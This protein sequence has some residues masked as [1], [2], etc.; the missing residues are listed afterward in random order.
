MHHLSKQIA[1]LPLSIELDGK[2]GVKIK[3]DVKFEF[4]VEVEVRI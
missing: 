2:V 4:I 1:Q 3:F